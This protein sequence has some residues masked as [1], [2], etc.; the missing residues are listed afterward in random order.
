MDSGRSPPLFT[1]LLLIHRP[2]DMLP[3]ALESVLAQ[4]RQSFEIF[5]V[6]DGAPDET[7]SEAERLAR[8]DDRI[9]VRAFPK[10]ERHGELY[11]AR[12][13]ETES[14]GRY[15]CHIDDDDLWMPG[16]LDGMERLLDAVDFGNLLQVAVKPDG[17]LRLIGFDLGSPEVRN[18]MVNQ[19]WNFFGP[20]VCGYRRTA[21]DRLERGWSPA[22]EDLP[23]DLFMWRKFLRRDDITAAT[24][25]DIGALCPRAPRRQHMT[26]AERAA[27]NSTL[28]ERIRDPE[29]RDELIQTVRRNAARELFS[30]RFPD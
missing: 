15:I 5:I 14:R 30:L 25:H 16:F 10:G 22:P 26:M 3:L 2:P 8:D 24:R 7:V 1:I 19:R 28:L 21:Y 9:H 13:I 6:C 27:E 20:S 18:R 12:V 4:G 11:R 17:G 29:S 23:T